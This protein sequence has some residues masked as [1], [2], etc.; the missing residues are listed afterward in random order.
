MLRRLAALFR[1]ALAWFVIVRATACASNT[2]LNLEPTPT[3]VAV[4]ANVQYYDVTAA[5]LAELRRG[6]QVL[7]PRWEGRAWSATT[8]SVFRWT[9][10]YE[11]RGVSCELRRVRVQVRTIVTFPRW[12]PT[13][14]PDSATLEWW[15]QLNAGLGSV[16]TSETSLGATIPL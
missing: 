10:D 6:M 1:V 15:H 2:R 3:G 16:Q 5:T 7:G 9:Y 12:N 11:Q 8:Q 13:A 4:D 14:P